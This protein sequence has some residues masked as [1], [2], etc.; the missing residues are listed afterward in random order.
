MD[1]VQSLLRVLVL[2]GAAAVMLVVV[3]EIAGGGML[4]AALLVGLAVLLGIA[5]T[6]ATEPK[7]MLMIGAGAVAAVLL[8]ARLF[9][10]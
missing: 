7:I 2:T 6:S 9:R 3:D 5:A 10:R 8:V 1:P 4:P